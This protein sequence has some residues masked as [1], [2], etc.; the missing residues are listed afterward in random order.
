VVDFH[1]A[2]PPPFLFIYGHLPMKSERIIRHIR[3]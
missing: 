2:L 1:Q 3:T